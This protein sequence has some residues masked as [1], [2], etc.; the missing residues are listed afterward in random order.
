MRILLVVRRQY[1]PVRW[2][3]GAGTRYASFTTDCGASA[4]SKLEAESFMRFS[5]EAPTKQD[6]AGLS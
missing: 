5:M 2:L 4:A 3:V 1:G 6:Y